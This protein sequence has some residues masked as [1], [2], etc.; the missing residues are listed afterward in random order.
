[1]GYMCRA[2]KRVNKIPEDFRLAWE[3]IMTCAALLRQGKARI[4][5]VTRKDGSTYRYTKLKKTE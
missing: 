3:E 1:M 5:T 4:V 2:E